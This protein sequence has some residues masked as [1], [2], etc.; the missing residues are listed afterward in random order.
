VALVFQNM[1]TAYISEPSG[2]KYMEKSSKQLLR[3][4]LNS[5]SCEQQQQQQ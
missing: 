1:M 5:S 2:M 3:T 4:G